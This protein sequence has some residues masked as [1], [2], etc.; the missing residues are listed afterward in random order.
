MRKKYSADSQFSDFY[1]DFDMDMD[2]WIRL[3][4]LC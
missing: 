4:Y 3:R 1:E 2:I